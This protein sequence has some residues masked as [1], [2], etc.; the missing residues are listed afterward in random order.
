LLTS[1][2]TGQDW[3]MPH[4]ELPKDSSHPRIACTAEELTRLKTAHAGNGPEHDVVAAVIAQAERALAQPL[5]FPPR[6]G[7]ANQWYQCEHCQIELVTVDD[8]HH[9]CPRCE[10]IYTGAPYDDVI[11]ARQHV[12]NLHNLHAAAWAYA[13]TGRREFADFTAKV[14]IGYAER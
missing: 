3:V 5:V 4:I 14:L 8:T 12:A 6:G 11:F 13:I 2:A 10:K 9:K 1:I 7:Q